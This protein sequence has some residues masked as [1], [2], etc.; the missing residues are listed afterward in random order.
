M[1]KITYGQ[2]IDGWN[3]DH[4][5]ERF[6]KY[7]MRE[8]QGRFKDDLINLDD[9]TDNLSFFDENFDQ[10]PQK[11]PNQASTEKTLQNDIFKKTNKIIEVRFS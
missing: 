2:I 9:N 1:Y 4:H 3:F 11:S 8:N 7:L 5:N 6:P 10:V